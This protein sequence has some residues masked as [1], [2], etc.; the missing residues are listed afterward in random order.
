MKIPCV[1]L[2]CTCLFL[3]AG[4][5]FLR[6]AC[7]DCHETMKVE[8]AAADPSLTFRVMEHADFAT[9]GLYYEVDLPVGDYKLEAQD[10]NFY[11]FHAN[12]PLAVKVS[13][14]GKIITKRK[15]TGGLMVTK[16]AS[17]FGH[18][19]NVYVDGTAFEEKIMILRLGRNFRR[20]K[21]I[22]W[23]ASF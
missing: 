8:P 18:E 20:S 14:N 13:Q 1:F 17:S 22:L 9:D 12:A 4:C 3:Q 21:D 2:A 16:H 10:A 7:I 5:A 11:Y 6:V 15:V 23:T 19:A